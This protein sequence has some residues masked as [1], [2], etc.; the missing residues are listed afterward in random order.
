MPP[1]VSGADLHKERVKLAIDRGDARA[2]SMES[3]TEATISFV[4]PTLLDGNGFDSL[5]DG[6]RA[7]TSH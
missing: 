3:F 1:V 4:G 7:A 6:Q 2:A 5:G